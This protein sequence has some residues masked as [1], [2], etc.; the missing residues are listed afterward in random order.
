MDITIGATLTG[1]SSVTLA[2]A[3]NLPGK[4]TFVAPAHAR[5]TPHTVE[6]T[7]S[8]GTPSGDNPGVARTGMKITFADRQTAE[9]CCTVAAGAVI[10]DLGVRW[11]LNQPDTLVD[12][13]V[14]YLRG[15]VYTVAFVN[16]IKKGILP[17]S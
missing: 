8:G 6:F 9:G 1:G 2:P 14:S 3:G 15:I 11:S 16:A 12:D 17:T 7:A 10:L 13:V 4:S 5:L